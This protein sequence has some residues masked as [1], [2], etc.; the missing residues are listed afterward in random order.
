M[1][2]NLQRPTGKKQMLLGMRMQRGVVEVVAVVGGYMLIDL[3]AHHE[4]VEQQ[5][6]L[7]PHRDRYL[8]A[9]ASAKRTAARCRGTRRQS[10]WCGQLRENRCA[11]HEVKAAR[12]GR[13]LGYRAAHWPF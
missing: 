11:T 7:L 13:R 4:A 6:Q 3:Q 2:R 9:R 8:G 1:A 12:G 10:R 5:M